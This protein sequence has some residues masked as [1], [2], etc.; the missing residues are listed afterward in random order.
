M[1]LRDRGT[2]GGPLEPVI[3]ADIEEGVQVP[4]VVAPGTVFVVSVSS[5]ALPPDFI[6][7]HIQRVSGPQA[8]S[9]N[10]W[11]L[12]TNS[13]L[14]APSVFEYQV[15]AFTTIDF[16]RCNFFLTDGNIGPNGFAG[17]A[18]LAN[19][20]LF[21]IIDD[22]GTTVLLDFLDG[23]PLQTNDQFTKL[24]GVDTVATF[25]AGDDFFPIRF[26]MSKAGKKMRLTAGQRIRWTNRDN[27]SAITRFQFMVQGVNVT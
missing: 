2:R 6:Y 11:D 5:S 13:S 21:E 14:V 20:C 16:S 10:D 3:I 17:L 26:T 25:A 24:A 4:V 27:L 7:K 8:A 19:G 12:N 15:P 22:D 9:G 1:A 18:A 23:I